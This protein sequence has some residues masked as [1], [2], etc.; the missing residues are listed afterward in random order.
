MQR[1]IRAKI[2]FTFVMVVC[3]S[4]A[5]CSQQEK[6]K[7]SV[8]AVEG[9]QVREDNTSASGPDV[10]FTNENGDAVSLQSLKGKVVFINFWATWCPPCIHEM[11]S[12]N[13][14]KKDYEGNSNIIF[15]M[16]DVDGK[17]EKSK[18][19]MKKNNYDLQVYI[20]K[21]SIPTEFLGRAIP[22][23]V[24]LDKEGQMISRIEGG[25]DYSNPEIAQALNELIESN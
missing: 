24:I 4:F 16:V 19:F 17:M 23:T 9:E 21:S 6:E 15:L 11:P 20:P 12:I 5:A 25:R 2:V 10:T 14:L 22:T 7:Q 3:F 18:A 8:N 1:N 13:K